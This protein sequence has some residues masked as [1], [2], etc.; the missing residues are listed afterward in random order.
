[1][2]RV[3]APYTSIVAPLPGSSVNRSSITP[4]GSAM[5]SLTTSAISCGW[6]G[7]PRPA[8]WTRKEFA[9]SAMTTRGARRSPSARPVRT[10]TIRPS[11]RIT[12][13]TVVPGTS[14]APAASACAANQPSNGTRSTVNALG[15]PAAG[16]TCVCPI[17]V[18]ASAVASHR[19]SS[20]TTRSI[21]ASRH[22]SPTT[23]ASIRP[24]ITPPITFLR[25]GRAPRS[26]RT[27]LRPAR[28]IV[29]AAAVPPGPAPT[30]IA[31]NSSAAMRRALLPER[32]D[33]LLH[34]R[35]DGPGDDPEPQHAGRRE[36]QPDPGKPAVPD[37]HRVGGARAQGD[38]GHA[39]I[40]VYGHH[41]REGA[42]ER[43]R[44][45]V[46]LEGGAEEVELRDEPRGRRQARQRDHARGEHDRRPRRAAQEAGEVLDPVR[47]LPP[48][49]QQQQHAERAEVHRD[50][51][52]QVV[53]H[54]GAARRAARGDPDQ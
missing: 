8:F 7:R 42:D 41:A 10:P 49:L 2:P 30:T 34:E 23:S 16:G 18:T 40:V 14:S 50:V 54:G 36:R 22:P 44:D 17:V 5:I 12:S 27:T 20:V 24:Y 53:E 37:R 35:R 45:P 1:M 48:A 46:V 52:Q 32:L 28:A 33:G 43:E 26:N 11:S 9:P 29:S 31:S 15:G 13:S 19:R 21:G 3:G 38:G 25:P 51:H 47:F 4:E 39:Q 6:S